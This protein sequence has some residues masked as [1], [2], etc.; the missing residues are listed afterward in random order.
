MAGGVL[1]TWVAALARASLARPGTL[2][3]G[4]AA[5]LIVFE[6]SPFVLVW[7]E[8]PLVRASFCVTETSAARLARNL[9]PDELFLEPAALRFGFVFDALHG[10]TSAR[11][12]MVPAVRRSVADLSASPSGRPF[13]FVAR[14]TSLELLSRAGFRVGRG[15]A[16]NGNDPGVVV[17]RVRP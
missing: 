17:A 15:I 9:G 10:P 2:A 1:A 7:P 6:A 5:L 11:S 13:F 12:P 8:D 4:F 16:P 14:R 3:A